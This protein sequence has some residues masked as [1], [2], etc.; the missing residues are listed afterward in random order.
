M[1]W[2]AVAIA[3]YGRSVGL[4]DLALDADYRLSLALDDSDA[5]TI[6]YL[7]DMPSKDILVA[8]ARP[9]AWNQ[10]EQLRRALRLVDFRIPTDW[11]VQVALDGNRLIFNLRIPER[12]FVH[13][14]LQQ[15]VGQLR[16]LQD[17]VR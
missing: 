1:D 5:L 4:P 3:E 16:L 12:S 7:A 14:V 13:N 15:A 9:L 8:C 11:P 17:K 6:V 2:I 10:P